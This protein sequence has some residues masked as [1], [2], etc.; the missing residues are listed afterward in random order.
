MWRTYRQVLGRDAGA[1]ASAPT[2]KLAP[3]TWRL[4]QQLP[5]W[6]HLRRL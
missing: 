1:H 5:Q 3:L 2:D 4:M 6:L